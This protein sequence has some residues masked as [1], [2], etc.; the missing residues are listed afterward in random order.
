MKEIWVVGQ[1]KNS[2]HTSS[3]PID[4][5]WS[6]SSNAHSPLVVAVAFIFPKCFLFVCS[7]GSSSEARTVNL[8]LR[9]FVYTPLDSSACTPLDSSACT[10]PNGFVWK[11]SRYFLSCDLAR[12][13]VR[14]SP[15][16]SVQIDPQDLDAVA[17]RLF[18][19]YFLGAYE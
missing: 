16:V 12:A 8:H 1:H 2:F 13:H 6:L 19:Q 10:L 4:A 15:H 18:Q 9:C 5:C 14:S 7:S 3:F 17:A 11:P